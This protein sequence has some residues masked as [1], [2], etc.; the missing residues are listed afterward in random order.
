MPDKPPQVLHLKITLPDCD[1]GTGVPHGQVLLGHAH[2]AARNP[3]VLHSTFGYA[4]RGH[5]FR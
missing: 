4:P 2:C 3:A 1:P 5:H